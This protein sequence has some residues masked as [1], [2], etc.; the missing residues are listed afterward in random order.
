MNTKILLLA[1]LLS[2]S[3]LFQACSDSTNTTATDTKTDSSNAM[4][5]NASTPPADN[6]SGMNS[7]LM[8]T[9][10]SSMM[11]MENMKMTGD[12]DYD[13]AGMMKGHHQAAIDMSQVELSKGSDAEIKAMAQKII[14]A[15]KKEI[16]QLDQF[17]SNTKAPEQK[18]ENGKAHNE[19]HEIGEKMQEDMKNMK[20]TGNMDKDFVMMMMM[21]HQAAVSMAKDELSHG[22]NI[23]LKQLA[24]Q[25]IQEQNQEIKEFQAWLDKNK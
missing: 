4:N 20:M 16:V 13:F 6:M 23:Q 14:D 5:N 7:E 1:S 10:N 17:L 18:M 24:Q 2:G 3:V 8:T 12:F 19:L 15:Q 11:K 21:H 9:M 22:K 25:I